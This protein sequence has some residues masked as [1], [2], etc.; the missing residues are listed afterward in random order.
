[1]AGAWKPEK[2]KD[3]YRQD[4][5]RRIKEKIRKRQTHVLTPPAEAEDE[6]P[7]AEIIDLTAILRKSL[8]HRG[9][10]RADP[11][12]CAS[13]CAVSSWRRAE[14][15]PSTERKQRNASPVG[16]RGVAGQQ[17][18]GICSSKSRT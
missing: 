13:A 1:M 6:R 14:A 8:K 18:R 16:C 5:M 11:Q 10:A 3:N 12:S 2:F 7:S 9:G 15:A 17:S 4:L